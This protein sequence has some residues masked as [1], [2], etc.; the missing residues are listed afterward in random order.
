MEKVD[1]RTAIKGGAFAATAAA[2]P[3]VPTAF[4]SSDA[5]AQSATNRRLYVQGS[6]EF[7][8]VS[9][10]IYDPEVADRLTADA[11]LSPVAT[12][13]LEILI[14][15]LLN[16]S[17][18][19]G[20]GD[21]ATPVENPQIIEKSSRILDQSIVGDMTTRQLLASPSDLSWMRQSPAFL[22]AKGGL[23]VV[24][25]GSLTGR[26]LAEG[27]L[28]EFGSLLARDFYPEVKG[29]FLEIFD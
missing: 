14:G 20:D 8:G 17:L 26:F 16:V 19:R 21:P 7:L 4:F 15:G 25:V 22:I 5:V 24:A 9:V 27:F 10:S 23:Y 11:E 28:G 18:N 2:Y 13:N 29:W 12:D 3:I 1:R 6:P